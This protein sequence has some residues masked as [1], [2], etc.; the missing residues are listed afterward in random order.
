MNR[1]NTASTHN[2][3]HLKYNIF[4]V[5]YVEKEQSC[6]PQYLLSSMYVVITSNMHRSKIT[7]AKFLRIVSFITLPIPGNILANGQLLTKEN[8]MLKY[9]N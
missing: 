7:I 5:L 4:E 9:R 8:V 2:Y 6:L 3:K 1:E